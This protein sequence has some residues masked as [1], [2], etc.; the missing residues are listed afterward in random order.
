[1]RARVSYPAD[2]RRGLECHLLDRTCPSIAGRQYPAA[3]PQAE[4]LDDRNVAIGHGRLDRPPA[5]RPLDARSQFHGLLLLPLQVAALELGK[6]LGGEQAQRSADI[7]MPVAPALPGEDDL[8][9]A[10]GLITLEILPELLRQYVIIGQVL[11]AGASQIPAPP[12]G[13]SPP[14]PHPRSQTVPRQ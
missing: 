11:Q 2:R 10:G 3:G 6:D 8:V 4:R 9:D 12:V 13:R 5:Q 14:A 7:L 1:M